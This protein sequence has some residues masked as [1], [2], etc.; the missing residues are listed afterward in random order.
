[1]AG[2]LSDKDENPA[3]FVSECQNGWMDIDPL[4]PV[5]GNWI[6]GTFWTNGLVY[7]Q[8]EKSKKM[9]YVHLFLI[10]NKPQHGLPIQA[11]EQ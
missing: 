6:N 1:L 5:C 2:F 11:I 8:Q 10:E 7:S 3:L 9:H 4:I